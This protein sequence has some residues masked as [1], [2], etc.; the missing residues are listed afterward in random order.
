[1][2]LNSVE[3]DVL[4]VTR[5]VSPIVIESGMMIGEIAEEID[6][7]LFQHVVLTVDASGAQLP[8]TLTG[9]SPDGSVS[10][11]TPLE[12]GGT[13]IPS[14]AGHWRYSWLSANGTPL[15]ADGQFYVRF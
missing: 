15:D 5:G 9:F 1:M 3:G 6:Y 13:I 2:T 8:T 14:V 4:T 10:S 11:Q 7:G 12:T